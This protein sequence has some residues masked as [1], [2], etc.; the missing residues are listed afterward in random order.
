MFNE[1]KE[2]LNQL[3]INVNR[4]DV[5]LDNLL[6]TLTENYS[7]T[8]DAAVTQYKLEIEEDIAR[9]KVNL[10]KRQIK[11]LGIVNLGAIKEFDEVNSR[12]EFLSTQK[13]D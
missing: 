2:I 9:N 4:L 1:K 7:L 12:Y 8:Y 13:T 11:E 10:L 3:E 5:K 6:N